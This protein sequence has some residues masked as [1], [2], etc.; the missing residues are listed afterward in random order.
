MPGHIYYLA[1]EYDKACQ[2]FIASRTLETTY[3]KDESIPAYD[4]KNYLH[5]LH[6]LIQAAADVED[7]ELSIKM[8]KELAAISTPENRAQAIGAQ[9][10]YYIAPTAA[11][12]PHIRARQFGKAAETLKEANIPKESAALHYLRFLKTNCQI[13]QLLFGSPK[14]STA[15]K[16]SLQTLRKRHDQQCQTLYACRA[17]NSAETHPLQQ[18]KAATRILEAEMQILLDNS[19]TTAHSTFSE[20][21]LSMA[22]YTESESSYNEPPLLP[23]PVSETIGWFALVKGH[24]KKAAEYFK[25]AL[26]KRPHSPQILHGLKRAGS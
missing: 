7:Y 23:T 10:N 5:N 14:L 6:Y 25:E 15:Q 12:I 1:G 24:P 16:K 9:I 2:A 18:A 22:L 20:A 8:A 21:W 17:K 13:K 3:L 26:K 11:A 4:N 19:Q